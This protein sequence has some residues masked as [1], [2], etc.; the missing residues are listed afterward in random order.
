MKSITKKLVAL[1][2]MMAIIVGTCATTS[3]A[4]A[5]DTVPE[6]LEEGSVAVTVASHSASCNGAGAF[7]L[8]STYRDRRNAMSNNCNY[9]NIQYAV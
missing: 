7:L 1:L 6:G 3:F 8:D 5:E 2:C 4:F 9:T